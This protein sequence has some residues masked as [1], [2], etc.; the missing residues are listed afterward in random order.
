MNM[1]YLHRMQRTEVN[2]Y[3]EKEGREWQKISGIGNR[4]RYRYKN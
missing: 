4:Y 3:M 1:P 2:S